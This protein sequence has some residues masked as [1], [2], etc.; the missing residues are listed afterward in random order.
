MRA[1]EF[2]VEKELGRLTIGGLTI[3]VD[4]HAMDQA[5]LRNVLPTDVDRTLRKISSIK[6]QIQAI[7]DGQQF[8]IFDQAQ[9][10]SLGM[11]CLNAEQARYVLKT[12]L[13]QHPYESPTP[14]ITIKGSTVDEGW[15]DVAAGVAT[16]GA[17]ALGSPPA[18]AKPAPGPSI[19]QQAAMTPIDKLRTAAKANGIRGTELAQFLAQCAHE[20]ANFKNMEEIG[21]ANY[22]A[23]K[24]DPKYAPKTAKILG[25]TKVGDGELYKGRGF[26]QLTGRDNY[27]RAGQALNL[28]L[29]DNPALAARPDVAAVIAVWYW[30]NRVASKVKNF[31]NTRQVTKAINPAGKGLQSRQD[32]FKQYQVAQR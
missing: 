12:V 17:L 4:D 5:V 7:D 18:D 20:S 8:W 6:D 22:F 30:K 3:I 31:H 25:N 27:T 16:A 14:V 13:D 15:K 9:D 21:D 23:R 2:I 10:I 24:Y 1:Q 11:R 28:P 29:A 19:Q 26:I 32:Q